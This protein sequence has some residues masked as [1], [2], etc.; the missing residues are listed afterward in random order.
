L[1]TRKPEAR[2]AGGAA[3]PPERVAPRALSEPPG[4]SARSAAAGDLGGGWEGLR[5]GSVVDRFEL[6]REIGRGGFGVV[7]EARDRAL[8]RGVAFK[9]VRGHGGASAA[10]ERLVREAELA[11][12]LSHP[13]LVTIHDAGWTGLGPYLVL[14]LLHGETLAERL[15]SGAAPGVEDAVRIA[16]DVARAVAHAH[17]Q[18]VVHRDLKPGN[19]FLCDD[20][21]VKVLDFGLA[22]A[23][24]QRKPE[25]GTPAFMAPE[26]WR[27]A[28]EDER[29][30]VFALGVI[31]FRMLAGAL[32]FP[33]AA[34]HGP[35]TPPPLVVPG[36]PALGPLVGRMLSHDPVDRPRHGDEVLAALEAL[37]RLGPLARV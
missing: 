22:H 29:T 4:E 8:G 3:E 34:G 16:T 26:Q 5:S 37:G 20:G 24:G 36:A 1:G 27:G 21:R 9:A 28:P 10:G 17:A 6:V 18:G 31:L 23:F 33:P 13:N 14:E 32:P 30:D 15:A 25:G 2:G 19:V 7:W 12:R 35:R 11:A